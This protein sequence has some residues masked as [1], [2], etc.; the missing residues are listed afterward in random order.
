MFATV[1]EI[2][3][4]AHSICKLAKDMQADL[5]INISAL[6]GLYDWQ[7]RA[8]ADS[9]MTTIHCKAGLV[10]VRLRRVRFAGALVPSYSDSQHDLSRTQ[11]VDDERV[12]LKTRTVYARLSATIRRRL[13]H[14]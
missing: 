7:F 8:Q 3:N 6:C 12:C 10:Q 11:F 2:Q 9:L 14:A 13:V 4:A 1:Q 5:W